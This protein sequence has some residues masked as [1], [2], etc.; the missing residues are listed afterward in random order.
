MNGAHERRHHRFTG[1]TRPSLR[2]GLN[3]LFRDPDAED[4]VRSESGII[5]STG[6]LLDRATWLLPRILRSEDKEAQ[7]YSDRRTTGTYGRASLSAAYD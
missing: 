5:P 4:Q 6:S 2:N 3:G 7:V 1:V